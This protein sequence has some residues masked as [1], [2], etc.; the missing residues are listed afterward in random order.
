M[1]GR[2][3]WE[4]ERPSISRRKVPAI[5]NELLDQFL[6]GGAASAAFE[7]GGLLDPLKK[8][9]TKRALI[10]VMDHQ[11]A[12]DEGAGNTL[13]GYGRKTAVTETGKL[14]IDVRAT[15]SRASTRS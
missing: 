12:G 10:A 1:C 7:Q 11:V 6:P 13:N 2:A 15:V 14:Q 8:A 3:L 5:P 9:L 4:I